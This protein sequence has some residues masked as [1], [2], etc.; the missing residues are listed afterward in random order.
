MRNPSPFEAP[1][2]P[3]LLFFDIDGTLFDD[4]HR[5]PPSVKPALRAAHENGHKLIINTGRTLCN[6]DERLADLPLDGWIMGC[7]TRII[8]EGETLRSLAYDP[9][10]S[11]RLR[12]VFADLALPVVFESDDAMYFEPE[13]PAYEAI[14][15]FRDY[16]E[17]HGLARDLRKNDPDF[18][19][20]KMFAFSADPERIREMERRT[21]ELGMPYTAI[22]R[23]QTGW[24]IV[25]AGYSKG[26]GIDFIRERL[27]LPREACY[28]F[29]DS[30]NDLTMLRHVAHSVAMGNA[31]ADVKAVCSYVTARPEEDGIE[32]AL[33]HFGLI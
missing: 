14:T 33:R 20:L 19:A 16:A 10:A 32:K 7:G 26:E 4:R 1:K 27:G 23:G 6:R 3:C 22:D 9:V 11:Q 25:P 12:E 31:E 29:G 28:A 18:H 15:Y 13:G 2:A 30:R 5:M 24:E 8:Y 21:A 17:Q